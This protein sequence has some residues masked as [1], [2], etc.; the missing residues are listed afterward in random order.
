MANDPRQSFILSLG[1]NYLGHLQLAGV[2]LLNSDISDVLDVY[3]H[4]CGG[5]KPMTTSRTA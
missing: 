3:S 5:F 2:H 4:R 1:V